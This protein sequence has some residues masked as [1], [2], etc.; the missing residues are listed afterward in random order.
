MLPF[1][2]PGGGGK[3]AEPGQGGREVAVSTVRVRWE[4]VL[5]EGEGVGEG[6]GGVGLWSTRTK[7]RKMTMRRR[8]G[9]RYA[10]Q[11]ELRV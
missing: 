6:K 5:T 9:K 8:G 11:K 3:E 4:G 2:V 10:A 7:G 1:L